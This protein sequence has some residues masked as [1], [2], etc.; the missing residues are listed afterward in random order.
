MSRSSRLSSS[1]SCRLSSLTLGLGSAGA[2]VAA[3]AGRSA[4]ARA[5][6]SRGNARDRAHSSPSGDRLVHAWG[7]RFA[8]KRA[9]AHQSA[10][11]PPAYRGPRRLWRLVRMM[12]MRCMA[13]RQSEQQSTGD[14]SVIWNLSGH[15]DLA[16]NRPMPYHR[17]VVRPGRSPAQAGA[18]DGTG[19]APVRARCGA[20]RGRTGRTGTRANTPCRARGTEGQWKRPTN[21]PAE[22]SC[23]MAKRARKARARKKKRANHGKRP[24]YR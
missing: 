3:V 13:H 12:V 20:G 6:T 8:L 24:T 9:H 15:S 7:V 5:P 1:S 4:R 14:Q 22:R 23:A 2:A 18:P 21:S 19:G 16:G 10:H 17:P 11:S